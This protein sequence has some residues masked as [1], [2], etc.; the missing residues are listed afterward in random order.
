MKRAGGLYLKIAEEE[1]LLAAFR[2]AARGKQDRT[3]VTAFREN[4]D[5][6]IRDLRRRILRKD[7]LVG[8]YRFFHVHDPKERFICAAAFP[9]RVLHHAI[10]NVCEPVLDACA[11]FDSYACRKGKGSRKSVLRC[12]EYARRFEWFLKL[13]IR[14]YFDSIQHSVVAT[15]LERRFKDNDLMWLF[16]RILDTYHTVPGKGLPIG[17]LISQHLA[18]FYLG[19]FDHW[20]KDVEGVKGY[21]RYMDDF[22]LWADDR[23]SLQKKLLRLSAWLGENLALRL[24]E[25]VQMNRCGRGISFLGY[26]VFPGRILLCQRSKKRFIRRLR[27]CEGKWKGGIWGEARLCRHVEPLIAFTMG[28]GAHGFRAKVIAGMG[29]SS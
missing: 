22:I 12:Q 4:L 15:L 5:A 24:K 21:V 18:N 14:R 1:N 16:R 29:V 6:N 8:D 13:D 26:R 23:H 7:V 3:E 19:P 17:N 28:A 27:A 20:I 10:M 11:V 25:N 2:K 9:E